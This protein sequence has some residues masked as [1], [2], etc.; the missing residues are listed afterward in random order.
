VG[1]EVAMVDRADAD[2]STETDSLAWL[3]RLTS[4]R[5]ASAV[6]DVVG[7][8]ALIAVDVWIVK[9]PPGRFEV[10]R[11]AVEPDTKNPSE[12]IALRAIEALRGSL[13]QIDWAARE[14]R[15]DS[16][17][18]AATPALPKPETRSATESAR[19]GLEVGGAVLTSVD[20][21]G[22]AVL[23]ILRVGWAVQ[24]WLVV[25]VEAAGLGNH[26]TVATAVG[27]AQVLQQFGVIGASCRLHSS[28]RMWPFFA[29]AAGVLH[30]S[31]EGEAGGATEA[32]VVD[33]WSLLLDGG[34][35]V[36][37]RIHGR[38]YA[39]LG[40]H[41]QLARPYVAIHFVDSVVATTG[42]PNMLVTLT[43]GAWL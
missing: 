17:A 40:A 42:R 39:T 1:L 13:L 35:G 2:R 30:T 4:E 32:H 43:L 12:R 23:P 16:I 14:R 33:T 36:G 6:V 15:D 8:D 19:F 24:P 9:K 37:V 26:A 18:S 25:H 31:V 34:L 10:T 28:Q 5:G 22:P 29:L 41:V 20:N 11:V 7:G 3:E 21:V 38:Y 27:S